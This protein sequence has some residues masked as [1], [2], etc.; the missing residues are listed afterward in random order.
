MSQLAYWASVS[1]DSVQFRTGQTYAA[2]G[3]G[4]GICL[5]TAR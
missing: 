1:A 2:L 3:T 4:V 5:A